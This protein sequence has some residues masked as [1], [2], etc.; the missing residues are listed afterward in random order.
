[1]KDQG[2]HG[3][4]PTQDEIYKLVKENNLMLKKMRRAAFVGGI[5]KFVWWIAI[6]FVIPYVL[7]ALYLQPYLVNI[8]NAY[9][10]FNS[11][12]GTVSGAANDFENLKNSIPNLGDLLKQFGGGGN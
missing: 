4:L 1:M 9:E 10:N 5:V 11:S 12:A 3:A 7:Y 8:Q 6:L 2:A